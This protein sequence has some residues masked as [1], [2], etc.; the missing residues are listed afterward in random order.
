[1]TTKFTIKIE[2]VTVKHTKRK[3][4]HNKNIQYKPLSS[5]SFIYRITKFA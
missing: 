1:M 4:N 5:N 3:S 2:K